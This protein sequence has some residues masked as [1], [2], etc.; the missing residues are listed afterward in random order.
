MTKLLENQESKGQW[1]WV[2]FIR[3]VG[4]ILLIAPLY[5]PIRAYF[6]LN[7][8]NV[9]ITK[10]E[11]ILACVGMF[12]SAGGKQIGTLLNNIGLVISSFLKR[13]SK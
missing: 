11:A 13:L 6:S 8:T 10:T 7:M 5:L 4:V 2:L 3:L 12:L 9:P 1:I